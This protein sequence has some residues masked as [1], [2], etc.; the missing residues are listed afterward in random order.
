M[1]SG[2][3][4]GAPTLSEL[5]TDLAL[6]LILAAFCAGVVDSIAGGGGLITVPAL[7]L[8]GLAPVEALATNKLQ[9]SFGSGSA[10]LAYARAGQVRLRDQGRLA[11][12]SFLAAAAGSGVALAA[13]PEA[14]RA[15]LP[16]VL[17]GVA[18]FF[19]LKRDLGDADRTVRM[20]PALFGA[21]VVPAVAFYDGLLGPGTG[22]F[23]MLGF[24]LLAG[25]GLLRA[26]AQTKTLNF[27][28]NLGALAV[29]AAAG[30]VWWGLGLAMALGQAAGAQ[31]GAGLAVR[32]G[33]RVI[34]PL[35][36]ATSLALAARLAWTG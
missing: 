19:L 6:V 13:P 16:V 25:L 35:L 4:T 23:F 30:G 7:L 20:R 11:G 36:V 10:M 2:G 34:R 24:V 32:L 33:A 1:S 3:F 17:A 5:A 9:G 28:S 15:V 27:A 22:S 29:F 31:L 26:T 18:L 8:A 12:V 14:L 21:T